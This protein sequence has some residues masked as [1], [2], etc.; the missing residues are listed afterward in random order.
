MATMGVFGV[1]GSFSEEAA[2]AYA[3]REG[4]TPSLV[5]LSELDGVLAAVEKGELDL[6]I[7]PVVN[8]IGGLVKPAFQA[9]GKYL[10]KPFDELWLQVRHCLLVVPGTKAD[11]ITHIVSHPQA[12]AQCK[13]Y[14]QKDFKNI[15]LREWGNTAIAAKD[16]AEGTLESGSAVIASE[17]CAEIYGLEVIAKNIQDTNPNLTAFILVKKWES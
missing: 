16:L 4:I 11:Q 6:G 14:L 10:F 15:E 17:R 1:V 9:M 5:Y 7:L 13:L 2:L 3:K 8:L 12:L